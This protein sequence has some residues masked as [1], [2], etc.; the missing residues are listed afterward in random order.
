[1]SLVKL[2]PNFRQDDID[3]LPAVV[4]RWGLEDDAA[5][6]EETSSSEY[7]QEEPVQHHCYVFPVLFDL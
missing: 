4:Q 3:G 6:P 5:R 2:P 1:M 7:P